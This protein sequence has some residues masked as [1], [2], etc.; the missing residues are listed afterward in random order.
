[1]RR[2]LPVAVILSLAIAPSA[3][4]GDFV[5]NAPVAVSSTGASPLAACTADDVAG[6]EA[7]G[8]N[9]F[10]SGEVEP[11]VAVDPTD[12]DHLVGAWQQDRWSDGG[13][14]GIVTAR[15]ANGGDTWASTTATK[16]SLCTGGTVGNKGDFARATD[17]WVAIAAD[18]SAVYLMTL[19]LNNPNT[20]ADHAMLVMKSTDGGATWGNPT[21][22]IRE[23]NPAVLNDKNSMTADPNDSDFVYAVWDRLEF[24]S[25][26]A[27][28]RAVENAFPFTGPV[29]FSRTTNGGTS[30]ETP[31]VIFENRGRITQTIGNQIVVLPDLNDGT[32]EGQLINGFTYRTLRKGGLVFGFDNLALI[33]SAD[34][35]VTWSKTPLIVDKM[36]ARGVT[37]PFDGSAVR[38][39]DLIPDF[40]VDPSDGTVY[41][42]WQDSRF[43]GFAYD[44][45]V[46]SQ[47]TDGGFTWSSPLEIDKTTNT[48]P[49]ENRQAFT[50]SV[51]VLS[52]GTVGVTYYD[53]RNNGVDALASDPLETDYF[54]VHCD[55]SCTSASNWAETQITPAS[56]DMRK[57]PVAR[58]DFVGDYEGLTDIG[59]AFLAF[60]GQANSAA[61]PSTIYSSSIEP[62]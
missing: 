49:I 38:S 17:P 48:G 35:G 57:A 52:D 22:L 21:P 59:A 55:G 10:L 4:A 13:A 47:S 2:L 3:L 50:P 34:R 1:M 58:G 5:A 61:D 18:G 29:L 45:I 28:A 42:V 19:S 43:N 62:D 32:L 25:A 16:S 51:H 8:S 11:W 6:Q 30:W 54:L 14:R 56:F 23:N 7:T 39:G 20:S 36:F 37:D 60:F 46:I 33:R 15:S 24:P 41:A 27:R 44:G 40:A 12:S 53:F 9:V 26:H 31:K